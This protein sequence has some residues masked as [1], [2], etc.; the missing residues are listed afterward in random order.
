M[1]G[2]RV[3]ALHLHHRLQLLP[4]DALHRA[5]LLREAGGGAG[6]DQHPLL[7]VLPPPLLAR[8]RLRRGLQRGQL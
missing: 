6:V 7:E 1:P 2:D 4:P 5:R 3:L 8:H